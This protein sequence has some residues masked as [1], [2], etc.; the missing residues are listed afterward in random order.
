MSKLRP[1]CSNGKP[2]SALPR[3]TL[4]YMIA[5]PVLRRRT[6]TH[7]KLDDDKGGHCAMGCFWDDNPGLS[8]PTDLIDEIA[9]VNDSI[10]FGAGP[11]KRW[12]EV[13]SWLR[14]KLRVI[15]AGGK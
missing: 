12:K 4:I 15:E 11:K 8:V 14:W 9:A 2:G 3:N 13:T 10:P 5:K 6:L 7:G 1:E